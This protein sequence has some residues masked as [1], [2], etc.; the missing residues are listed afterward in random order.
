M[1]QPK[2]QVFG[3]ET[4]EEGEGKDEACHDKGSPPAV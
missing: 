4:A 2:E 1:M 3:D